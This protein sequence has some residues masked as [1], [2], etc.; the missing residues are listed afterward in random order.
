MPAPAERPRRMV[1]VSL[2]MY[3]GLAR[4]ERWLTSV[5]SLARAGDLPDGVDVVVLPD[6]V[7]LTTARYLLR[8]TGVAHG[9]QD[10]FWERSGA[11]TGEV[12]A[13]VLAEAG[14]GYAE[15]G[16]AERRRIFGEDDR[17]TARKAAAA[18]GAGLTPVVCVG[19]A[20]AVGP[21]AAV[22]ECAAQV[23]PVLAAV[24]PRAPVV[25]AYEPV[26]AIGATEPASPAH[27]REVVAGLR[28]TVPERPGTTRFIYGGSAGPGLFADVS[29]AV[30]GLFLGRFAHDLG[31]LRTVLAEVAAAG[32]P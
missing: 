17:V 12:S 19:E 30:D 14:C 23:A 2:K 21:R 31:N 29:D 26:R 4:T 27:I 11:F 8:G 9:A 24:G 16:H 10:V 7:S 25:F 20:D 5:A 6:F 18:V 3:F 22:E 32:G 15:V 1:G 28:G 13:D